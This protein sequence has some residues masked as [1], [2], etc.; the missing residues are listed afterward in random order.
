V[1]PVERA[2]ARVVSRPG[3]RLVVIGSS[4]GGPPVLKELL[5]AMPAPFPLPVL[6]A[7]HILA[8]FDAGL[9]GWLRSTGH[10]VVLVKN[11]QPL[12]P[13]RVY[14]APGDGHMVVEGGVVRVLPV[15]DGDMVPSAD[16]L[17]AS[18]SRSYGEGVVGVVLTGMGRD[19]TAGLAAIHRAGGY[20]IAQDE[21]TSGVW[22]MPGSAVEAGLAAD[23]LPLP[24]VASAG[25]A[26]ATPRSAG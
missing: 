10:D 8:G 25:A 20:V 22:G 16:K 4:T 3:P 7:Q 9:A 15:I 21:A 5:A 11:E 6:I 23:V 12:L 2:P 18:A 13:G 24:E 1:A 14:V 19:G 17:L 26:L